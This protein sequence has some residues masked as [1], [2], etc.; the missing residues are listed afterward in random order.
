V[1]IF[2]QPYLAVHGTE[3][4]SQGKAIPNQLV[5][6]GKKEKFDLIG[7]LP[8][9]D[10]LVGVL[11]S[12]MPL[13]WPMETLKAQAVAARS[14][15]LVTMQERSK[16]DFHLE[17]TILDQ[18]FTH[19]GHGTDNSPLVAKAKVAVKET[20]GFILVT[21]NQRT[22]KAFYHSDCG[23]KT[24][25]AKVVWGYG[26]STGSA[27]DRS[28]PGNP[29][30][31]WSL[32]VPAPSLA[33]KLEAF[34]KR[35]DLGSLQSLQLIRPSKEDRVEK[36]EVAF[37][38]GERF[39]MGSQDFRSVVGFDQ[40]R[41]TFFDFRKT[42]DEYEFI[43]QGFGHGV[44]LCQW[45]ARSMGKQGK[46]YSEILTHYYPKAQLALRKQLGPEARIR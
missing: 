29:K 19:I 43:G 7:V 31:H 2:A 34:L 16:Q 14:Y 18:V 17:S 8:L 1:E 38:N 35:A 27:V 11:A 25:D 12:E 41:S 22:L 46:N 28:C 21:K 39:L 44:G 45:G 30:A 37:Q 5:F 13:N 42:S 23:G 10:Y 26:I 6:S 9:E 15:A 4:S 33:A 40:L 24:A 20:A 3:L 36:V 32:K